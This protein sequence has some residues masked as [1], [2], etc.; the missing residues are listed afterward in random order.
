MCA[1]K[2]L[3]RFAGTNEHIYKF[4]RTHTHTHTNTH[5]HTQIHT[6]EHNQTDWSTYTRIL[7]KKHDIHNGHSN[8]G[9]FPVNFALPIAAFKSDTGIVS[10]ETAAICNVRCQEMRSG[11]CL[12][13]GVVYCV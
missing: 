9:H 1:T 3:H 2:T 12:Q 11:V 6:H 4:K 10:K 8:D 7:N 13:R 5:T